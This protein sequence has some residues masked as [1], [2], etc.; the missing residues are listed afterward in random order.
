MERA[1]P[2]PPGRPPRIVPR[3]DPNEITRNREA[4]W[5]ETRARA[6]SMYPRDPSPLPPTDEALRATATEAEAARIMEMKGDANVALTRVS[7]F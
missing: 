4:T 6:V 5:A 1:M 2:R 3:T 7:P